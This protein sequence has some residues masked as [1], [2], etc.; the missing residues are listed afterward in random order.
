[1]K[2][3]VLLVHPPV[4][5]NLV[6]RPIQFSSVMGYGLLHIAACLE[7]M[8]YK[9]IVWD[10][11]EAYRMRIPLEQIQKSLNTYDPTVIGVE[12]NWVAF[13]KGAIQ[14]AELFKKV[15]PDIPIVIGGMHAT[16]FANEIVQKHHSVI[17]AV[18]KGEAEKTFPKIVKN[19]E[20]KEN[21]GK[22]GGLVT[23]DGKR[24]HE[25]PLR[26]NDIYINLDDIPLCSYKVVRHIIDNTPRPVPPIMAINTSRGPCKFNCTYCIGRYIAPL[27]GR[28]AFS[29]HSSEW[30]VDQI[31]IYI[32]EGVDGITFQDYLFLS[33]KKRLIDLAEAIQRDQINEKI[34]GINMIAIPGLLSGD[35]LNQLSRAGVCEIDYGAESGSNCVLRLL[36][37]PTSSEIIL[38]SV[39]ATIS[40][41][42]VPLTWWMTGLPNE[43]IKE[44]E[45]TLKLINKT[46]EEGSIP[47][48]ITPLIIMPE[49]ELF[50]RAKDYGISLR[51]KTF[52]EFSIY[53]D[54]EMKAVP[55]HPEAISHET[56][57]FDRYDILR[58]TINMKLDIF[59][60]REEIVKN[61]IE[62]YAT[63]VTAY[64][65][66]LTTKLLERQIYRVLGGMLT[67]HW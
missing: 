23:F 39:K 2:V 25:V 16:I 29:T 1:M 63:I 51:L 6:R 61:F 28:R 58:T 18:L 44:V 52:E 64:H 24:L 8:G 41:G 49:T 47:K 45:E 54:I 50:R 56:K 13:S 66:Q 62:K 9:V 42:I 59:S 10:L 14:T 55:W 21:I 31:N 67:T 20:E 7:E 35:T 48:W 30:I 40:R 38:D 34:K 33:E 17:D 15:R 43:G 27:S 46:I 11:Q 53:S 65:P 4:N 26:K 22:V 32:D 36:K 5:F 57:Y 12:L 3:D 37:R 19:L 60:R